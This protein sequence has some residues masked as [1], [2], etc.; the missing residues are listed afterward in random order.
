MSLSKQ[1]NA[2]WHRE[3]IPARYGKAPYF[4]LS[5]FVFFAWK[6][7]YV[8]PSVLELS[9]IALSILAFLPIY[10]YSFWVHDWRAAVCIVITCSFG[11]LWAKFNPGGSTFVI[12]AAA[13]CSRFQRDPRQAY[14]ALAIVWT[15]VAICSYVFQFSAPFW[16]PAL[17][18]SIPSTIG[19]IIGERLERANAKLFRKQEEIEHLARLAERER[20]ARDLHDLL[21]HTLSVITLKAELARKL[22]GRD[23]NAC[24]KEIVE[25]EQT[26][27]EALAEVRAAVL[28]YRD[29]GL[30][31]ELRGA[32]NTL[33][34]A[35]VRFITELE[36]EFDVGSEIKALPAAVEN[37]IALALREAIT[38]II[39]HSQ[40]TVCHLRLHS[41]DE[42]VYFHLSDN[43]F[44]GL[45]DIP[46]LEK[47]NGLNGMS[48]RV[49]ALG[50]QLQT[51]CQ[52]GVAID[53]VLPLKSGNE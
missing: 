44:E 37:V 11:L 4:W 22:F 13:M 3:W 8:T 18:F 29:T 45:T 10:L 40:A 43:G 52:Q 47:G 15:F 25:I 42:H 5:S 48:E 32:R 6:Y 21:G 16:V 50:G 24:Q 7:V 1:L 26:A 12:F 28:G 30:A 2:L 20:I 35:Q 39:R 41:D 36:G 27:R 31:H 34:S 51:S 53:I 33:D 9:L 23:Q 49:R 14:L 38:N 46:K 17:I 19:A